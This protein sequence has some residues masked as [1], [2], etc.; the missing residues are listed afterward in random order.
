ME[1]D[2]I[3]LFIL[4]DTDIQYLTQALSKY[5]K[6]VEMG[7]KLKS[8]AARR[9]FNFRSLQTTTIIIIGATSS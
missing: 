5:E 4:S 7:K 9:F 3:K 1:S 6:I 8:D 2:I